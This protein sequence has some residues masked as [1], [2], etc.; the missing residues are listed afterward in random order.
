MLNTLDLVRPYGD[1]T[2]SGVKHHLGPLS[3]C[4]LPD[5]RKGSSM[6]QWKAYIAEYP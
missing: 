6:K 5:G 2:G 3:F 1:F 4:S